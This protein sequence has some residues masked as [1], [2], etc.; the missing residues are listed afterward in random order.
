MKRTPRTICLTDAAW[1]AIEAMAAPKGYSKS[2]LIEQAVRQRVKFE[3]VQ[4][5]YDLKKLPDGW[6]VCS[7]TGSITAQY[8]GTKIEISPDFEGYILDVG[9]FPR[10]IVNGDT[11]DVAILTAKFLIDLEEVQP[12]ITDSIMVN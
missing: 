8:K 7:L 1:D 2:E 3:D 12:N 10:R 6:S 9:K 4:P 11:I 5:V